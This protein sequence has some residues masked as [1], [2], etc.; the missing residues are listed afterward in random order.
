MSAAGQGMRTNSANG[1]TLGLVIVIGSIICGLWSLD[2]FLART[3]RE[4]VQNQAKSLHTQGT[5]ALEQGQAARA[6]ELLRRANSLVR[7]DRTYQLV[8]CPRWIFSIENAMT[9]VVVP[10]AKWLRSFGVEPDIAEEFAAQIG[11]RGEDAAVND[12]SLE[13]GKPDFD[14]IQPGAIGGGEMEFH[15]RM[16]VQE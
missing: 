8:G 5:A 4:A 1:P 3:D 2:L 6:V 16:A 15:V 11:N 13:S 12:F 14:L 10:P 7:D 9:R